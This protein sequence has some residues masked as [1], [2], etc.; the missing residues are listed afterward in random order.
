MRALQYVEMAPAAELANVVMTYW[1]FAIRALPSPD[2][3]HRVWPD[4]CASLT[5][6]F[7]HGECQL[8]VVLGAT[9][10]AGVVSVRAGEQYWGIRFRPEA[11]AQFCKRS[12]Q[13]LRGQRELARNVFDAPFEILISALTNV[14]DADVARIALNAFVREQRATHSKLSSTDSSLQLRSKAATPSTYN[15]SEN[16]TEIDALSRAEVD[17]IVR[18]DGVCS[19]SEI[20][21]E[22]HVSTRQLQRRFREATGLTPKAYANIR[23]ARAALKRVAT[24]QNSQSIGGWARIAIELGYSDQA[25]LSREC[26]R[27]L[28]VTPTELLSTL[29]NIT[30]DRLVD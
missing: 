7:A 15:E 22:L 21:S 9:T 25:H 27:L 11:G 23:R 24:S 30:H 4:G 18:R 26:A 14:S 10:V 19:I 2:F 17:S 3:M 16:A 20:A 28:S 13:G 5:L 29:E 6:K 12:A 8:A 1:G